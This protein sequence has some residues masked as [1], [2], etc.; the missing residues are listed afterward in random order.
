DTAAEFGDPE[1]MVTWHA[2]GPGDAGAVG[3]DAAAADLDAPGAGAGEAAG[4]PAAVPE[5]PAAAADPGA[6]PAGEGAEAP[7]EIALDEEFDLEIGS[8]ANLPDATH[9]L[10]FVD[11]Y[12]DPESAAIPLEAWAPLTTEETGEPGVAEDA[13]AAPIASEPGTD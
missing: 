7:P 11:E 10:L 4:E 1:E 2:A 5:G 3:P 8:L 12:T 6:A 13:D 9:S